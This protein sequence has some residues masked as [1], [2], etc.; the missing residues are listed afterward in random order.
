M[1]F[2]KIFK[3]DQKTAEAGGSR[4]GGKIKAR[5]VHVRVSTR[6]LRV[7]MTVTKL[8]KPW[9]ESRYMFQYVKIETPSDIR[10][11]Q[12]ECSFVYV[13]FDEDSLKAA[14]R[15]NRTR[16][17]GLAGNTPQVSVR[18]ELNTSNQVHSLATQ[19][20]SSLFDDM[21]LGAELNGTVVK[22]AVSGCVE[23]ILR[24][25][26][27]S[28]WLTRMKNKDVGTAKHSMNVSALSIIMAKASGMSTREMEDVGV[29]GMLHDV[30]KTRL[31]SSILE[32]RGPLTA[33]E[34]EEM[35]RHT[36]YGRDILLSSK[37]V[38]SGA[39]DVAHS[40]HERPDGTGFPNKLN[41]DSIPLY[42]K[43]VSIAEA[44]DNMTTT[45][46]YREACSP[47]LALQEI[48]S[49]RGQQFDEDLI[50]LFIEAIGIFP[51]GSIVEM[52]NNEVGI[53]LANTADKLRPRVIMILDSFGEPTSQ[54]I[55]DLSRLET[56]REGAIYQIKTTHSDGAFGIHIDEF[57]RAGLRIG[58]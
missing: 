49:Q 23:S 52:V 32:K 26:D 34:H 43:I 35:R 24:N 53:V 33:S 48:Y 10:D 12:E 27:A 6:D 7:G 15:K 47:S 8:D 38:M 25:Q 46:V 1:L 13:D 42:A 21:R 28:L 51:P 30:G 4:A 3:S 5:K 20:V 54:R 44:Y 39:A 18:E 55:V 31:P 22:Q 41:A 57:Q 29:C 17:N 50:I 40:H 37:N 11:M 58:E 45:Q 14:K 36:I 56:D 9:E 2:N 16:D 19:A